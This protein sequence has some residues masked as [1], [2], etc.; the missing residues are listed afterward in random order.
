MFEVALFAET[1]EGTVY[2]KT[3][4]LPFVPFVGLL[5]ETGDSLFDCP[6]V[7]TVSWWTRTA[8]FECLVEFGLGGTVQLNDEGLMN[9][10]WKLA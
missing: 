5:L 7:L 10:G 4:E 2:T 8:S 3:I 6:R 1:T 9:R